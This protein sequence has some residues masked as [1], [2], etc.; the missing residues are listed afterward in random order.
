LQH[1]PNGQAYRHEVC[2]KYWQRIYGVSNNRVQ[3]VMGVVKSGATVAD[4]ARDGTKLASDRRATT[5]AYLSQYFD[6]NCDK[7]PSVNGQTAEW[8]LPSSTTKDDLYSEYKLWCTDRG[9]KPVDASYYRKIWLKEFKHVTI[10]VR[11]RFKECQ[12]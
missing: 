7:Q 6:D 3:Q 1:A 12:T 2:Q 11:S 10:P 4:N 9:L 8:H 5:I